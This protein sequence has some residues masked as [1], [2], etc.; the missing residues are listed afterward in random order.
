[1]PRDVPAPPSLGSPRKEFFWGLAV[2]VAVLSVSGS[3]K[4]PYILDGFQASV[5]SEIIS[6]VHQSL[7]DLRECLCGTAFDRPALGLAVVAI[8]P[9]RLGR[10]IFAGKFHK[11]LRCND[12]THADLDWLIS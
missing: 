10:N 12:F 2:I 11:I 3:L 8:P 4:K 1:M 9:P 6:K 5:Y 7:P